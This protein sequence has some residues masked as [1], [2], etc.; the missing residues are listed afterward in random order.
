[1]RKKSIDDPRE[2][3]IPADSEGKLIT[4]DS[5]EKPVNEKTI[6]DPI[7][8]KSKDNPINNNPQELVMVYDWVGDEEKFWN[9]NFGLARP[10]FHA[11]N[12]LKTEAKV[13]FA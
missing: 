8:V 3:S 1:M 10:W 9:E 7:T 13:F 4:E 5:N 6:E 2:E 12:H 11:T